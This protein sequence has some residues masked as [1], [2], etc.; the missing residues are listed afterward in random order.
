[1]ETKEYVR[2]LLKLNDGILKPATDIHFLC[3]VTHGLVEELLELII[4]LDEGTTDEITKERGDVFAYATL[5]MTSLQMTNPIHLFSVD[6]HDS[7]IT[8]VADELQ[9]A[10]DNALIDDLIVIA[11][12]CAGVFKRASRGESGINTGMIAQVAASA[13]LVSGVVSGVDYKDVLGSNISKLKDRAT[14]GRID[15]GKGDNR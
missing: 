11:Q 15:R 1:M 8:A 14:R 9:S 5:L 4:V 10:L 13:S 12:E 2:E 6:F 7:I 3:H